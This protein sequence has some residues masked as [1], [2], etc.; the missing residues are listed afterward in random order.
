MGQCSTLL[1]R[2]GRH[3]T[4]GIFASD[5]PQLKS[6]LKTQSALCRDMTG[7]AFSMSVCTAVLLKVADHSWSI[8]GFME[9]P[10]S[11]QLC[12][13]LSMWKPILKNPLVEILRAK[14]W[15]TFGSSNGDFLGAMSQWAMIYSSV[16]RVGNIAWTNS[17]CVCLVE[18]WSF[19]H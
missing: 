9:G 7:N 3:G 2:R 14:W 10:M 18:G 13:A 11:W 15:L 16:E 8:F 6:F 5:F 1:G 19:A 17:D 4:Q 12:A